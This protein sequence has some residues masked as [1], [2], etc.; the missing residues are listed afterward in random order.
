[1]NNRTISATLSRSAYIRAYT[2]ACAGAYTYTRRVRACVCMYMLHAIRAHSTYMLHALTR[3]FHHPSI[4]PSMHKRTHAHSHPP[5]PARTRAHAHAHALIYSWRRHRRATSLAWK[6]L[7]LPTPA[8]S[9]PALQVDPF[10][11]VMRCV[12]VCVVYVHIHACKE[13][14]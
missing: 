7:L 3:S 1:M 8:L 9:M 12:C 11:N 14:A 6:R 10:V 13:S 5:T 2:R 4:H